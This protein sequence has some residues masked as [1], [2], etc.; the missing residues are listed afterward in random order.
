[1]NDGTVLLIGFGAMGRDVQAQLAQTPGLRVDYVL[2]RPQR[3]DA[4]QRER[5]AAC[6]VVG[7]LEE[8]PQLPALALECA[9]HAAVLLHVPQLLR[10]G[11]DTIVASVGS[12]AS[13]G[14]AQDL[15]AAC[16]AGRARLFLAP[17]ALA[18]IDALAAASAWG[19][20]SVRYTGRKPPAGWAGT[21]AEDL[22]DL[23]GLDAPCTFFEGSAREAARRFPKNANVA[24]MVGLAGIGLDATQVALVA[25]PGVGRNTHTVSASGLFGQLDVSVQ[26]EPS[27]R[28]PRT[29]AL[30]AM[31]IV[32]LVRQR[33]AGIVL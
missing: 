3:R 25:D 24:A 28:N 17:G 15:A 26:A 4:L 12:L 10:Q 16:D 8:L 21:L 22:C 9:G 11:V 27:P 14:V 23:R 20:D 1:M 30:A 29:S 32:R 2:E 13:A 18:G 6:R 7:S 33:A 5:G 31:S 19:L